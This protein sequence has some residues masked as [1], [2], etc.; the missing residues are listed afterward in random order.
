MKLSATRSGDEGRRCGGLTLTRDLAVRRARCA[1]LPHMQSQPFFMAVTSFSHRLFD[2]STRRCVLSAGHSLHF[3]PTCFNFFLHF[4][5]ALPSS[6]SVL[7]ALMSSH[8]SQQHAVRPE[9]RLEANCC[10]RPASLHQSADGDGDGSSD[11]GR[12]GIVPKSVRRPEAPPLPFGTH[13]F[14]APSAVGNTQAH[15][16]VDEAH[17]QS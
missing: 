17:G 14:A 11:C 4:F 13:S 6:P 7:H 3:L 10:S 12:F 2:R 9:A 5:F 1:A 16:L 8:A 15:A